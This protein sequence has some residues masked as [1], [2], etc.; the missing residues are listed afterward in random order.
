[1]LEV[2]LLTVDALEATGVAP[3]GTAARVRAAAPVVDAAFVAD[4]ARREAVTRH[5]TAAFVDVVQ[6]AMQI[7]DASWVHY[8]LTSSDVVDTALSVQLDPRARRPPGRRRRRSSARSPPARAPRSTSPSRVGRTGCIAEPT[9]FGAKFA[10]LALQADRDRTRLARAR[11]GDRRRQALRCG[12]DVLGKSSPPSRTTCAR[13]LGLEPVPATQVLARDRHAEVLYACASTTAT[14]ET[15]ATEVRLLSRS[16]VG[17]AA[18]PFAEGQKGSSS[19]PHKHNPV[20]AERLCGLARVVRGYVSP[21]LEDVALWHE[22]DI[23]H[24]SVE[25]VVLPDALELTCFSLRGATALAAGLVLHAER[26][27]STSTSRV[28][29]ARVLPVGAD[30]PS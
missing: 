9:T 27:R 12:R 20:L 11:A 1:M 29:R 22:R 6:S 19:M 26:A 21:G 18:E 30:S 14:I 13:A 10:L 4:V 17:E 7:P 5:D 2:E 3:G 8:G 28:A 24:S 15:F 16:D 23:S 25:R